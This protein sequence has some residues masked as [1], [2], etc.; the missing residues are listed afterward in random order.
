[1]KLF[2]LI[3]IWKLIIETYVAFLIIN[4]IDVSRNINILLK[5]R[6]KYNVWTSTAIH[7][8]GDRKIT[9]IK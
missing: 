2:I 3:N 4:C 8:N 6:K 1:M 7:L 5:I 9:T